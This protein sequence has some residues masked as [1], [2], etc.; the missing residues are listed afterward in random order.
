[1]NPSFFKKKKATN[2]H[3]DDKYLEY[4]KWGTGKCKKG[5]EKRLILRLASY[6]PYYILNVIY[7]KV[8]LLNCY[9]PY[10]LNKYLK[11]AYNYKRSLL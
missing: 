9:M 3:F 1:M 11:E 7:I 5:K 2:S 8:I 10:M 6:L 4:K